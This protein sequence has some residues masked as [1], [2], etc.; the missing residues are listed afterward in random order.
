MTTNLYRKQR[1]NQQ[2]RANEFLHKYAFFAFSKEQFSEGLQKLGLTEDDAKHLFRIP[3]GGYLLAGKAKDFTKMLN[4]FAEERKA[5]LNDPKTGRSF[6][7]DMFFCELA[8]HEYCYTGNPEEALDALG[9]TA[10]DVE[11]DPM[12]KD[13]LAQAKKK[14][15]GL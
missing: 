5:A 12:L 10:E 11:A 14:A 4:D 3:G 15:G 8:N 6:A 1:D 2:R 7:Y 9:Y 13:A